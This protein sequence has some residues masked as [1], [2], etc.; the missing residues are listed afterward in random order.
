MKL[1]YRREGS[2]HC[3]VYFAYD[4]T[5]QY[6]LIKNVRRGW[7]LR[8]RESTTT[9]GVEHAIGQPTLHAWPVDTLVEGR[10]VAQRYHN[11]GDDYRP[12]EH[13]YV[14][15]FALALRQQHEAAMNELRAEIAELAAQG[16]SQRCAGCGGSGPLNANDRCHRGCCAEDCCAEI[17]AL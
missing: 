5:R 4:G 17:A 7:T 14:D 2:K 8:I 1:R 15:R 12:H 13:S 16:P 3:P 9:A 10:Q 6:A 11:L